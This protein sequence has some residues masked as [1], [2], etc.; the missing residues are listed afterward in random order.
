MKI[1][2][3]GYGSIGT[4]HAAN[5]AALGHKVLVYDPAGRRDVPVEREI[6][7]FCDAV[8]LAT[9]SFRHTSGIRACVERGKHV[10]VE[11]P[12]CTDDA[13]LYDLLT[14]ADEKKLV[15]MM[16]NNLR[17]H[18]C[19]QR[20]SV[21]LDAGSPP[22]WA[23]FICATTTER[24][25]ILA[26]GVIL[27]TGSHEVDMALHLLGPAHVVAATT[28]ES[29]ERDVSVDF[30]LEHACGARSNFHLDF[31][32]PVEVR[33]AW[34][35]AGMAGNMHFNLPARKAYL[36][37]PEGESYF[38]DQG[39]YGEDYIA[40]MQAFVDRIEGKETL[41]ASGWD[42]LYTLKVLLDVRRM[43]GLK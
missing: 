6:Y 9:P 32:T 1:G 43:A 37:Q 7:E 12:I 16:G 26:D 31:E 13:G 18:P 22:V 42:G 24:T 40:E 2:I 23:N 41:G 15:V 20:A 21:W 5:A 33:E 25:G 38:N 14:M 4:R 29:R 28:T 11:K 27:N 35:S 17:F 30:V 10:L 39:S 36:A 8:V 19:V 3:V 34:I